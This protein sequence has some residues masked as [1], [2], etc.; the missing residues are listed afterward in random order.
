MGRARLESPQRYR[1]ST[2]LWLPYLSMAT[3][4]LETPKAPVPPNPQPWQGVLR[5]YWKMRKDVD[6]SEGVNSWSK[7]QRKMEAGSK[8]VCTLLLGGEALAHSRHP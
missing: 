1:V 8:S 7:T 5:A 2:R 3:S 4:S 6:K